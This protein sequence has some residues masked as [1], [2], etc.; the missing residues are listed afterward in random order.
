MLIR[1]ATTIEDSKRLSKSEIFDLEDAYVEAQANKE[2][3]A[4][5][6]GV[7]H[8]SAVG[9]CGR[10]NVYE[11]VRADFLPHIEVASLEIFDLGHA[12][13]D[14]IQSKLE[15]LGTLDGVTFDFQTEVPYDPKT[16]SLYLDMHIGG[17]CDGVLSI[18]KAGEWVQR[19]V[20]EIKSINDANFNKVISKN[21]PKEEH[22]MQ[23]HL[24]AYRFD[25]PI[26]WIWYY[27]KNNSKRKVFPSTF[28]PRIFE[29]A[30][31]T[32]GRLLEHA[33]AGTLPEKDENWYMCPRCEYRHICKPSVLSKVKRKRIT[34]KTAKP[35]AVKK[36][37]KWSNT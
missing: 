30:T 28:D 15:K 7:F 33:E 18:E 22:L 20:V 17:T 2:K 29:K 23:A 35:K 5:R 8:P 21:E 37:R 9:G 34:P 32:F 36:V 24:Y 13:H 12:I 11:Y 19:G 14:I 4:D 31:G 1:S 16:D 27:N 25:A 26:I 6:Q 10:R 3:D